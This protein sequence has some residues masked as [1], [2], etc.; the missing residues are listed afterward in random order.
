MKHPPT[1]M[2]WGAMSVTGTAGLLF[3]PNG[4]TMNGQKYVELLKDKLELH[5]NVHICNIFMQDGTPCHRS[6]IVSKFL[7][8]KI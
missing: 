6:K 1:V 5:M 7:K 8:E 2:I 4:T 3:L